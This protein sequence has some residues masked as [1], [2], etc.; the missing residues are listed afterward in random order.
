MN[1][2]RHGIIAAI[3]GL[4]AATPASAG[5]VPVPVTSD[6]RVRVVEYSPEQVVLLYATFGYA[7]SIQFEDG[8][9]LETVSVGNSLDW[10]LLPNKQA[11]ILFVKPVRAAAPTNMTVVT[12]ARVYQF[13]LHSRKSSGPRDRNIIFS[14]RFNYP[15]PALAIAAEDVSM[16]EPAIKETNTRYSYQGSKRVLPSRVFD[17]G[18]Q[19]YFQFPQNSDLPAIFAIDRDRKETTVNVANRDGY[20]VVDR[21]AQAF[22]LR[23]GADVTRILN[24]AYPADASG[25]STL[26][27]HEKPRR[28]RNKDRVQP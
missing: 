12:N 14:L 19:T 15:A 20:L 24:D 10:Q 17:D 25:E 26:P 22:V 3:A 21:I 8:E 27:L 5:V 23:K 18:T 13:E 16:A 4:L 28:G 2:L 1:L 6:T 9:R 11:N 7:L